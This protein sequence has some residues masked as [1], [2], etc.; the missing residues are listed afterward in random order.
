MVESSGTI[1]GLLRNVLFL[2]ALSMGVVIK[3]LVND[4]LTIGFDDYK[5]SK[6]KAAVDLNAL[7]KDLIKYGGSLAVS[8]EV[9]PQGESCRETEIQ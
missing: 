9:P 5:L 2:L 6:T 3:S 1:L 8:G 4:T 7:Q